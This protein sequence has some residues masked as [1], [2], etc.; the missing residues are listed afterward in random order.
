[1][2]TKGTLSDNKN[3]YLLLFWAIVT[4]LTARKLVRTVN[5]P[6]TFGRLFSD[7]RIT[8][9][10][11][12]HSGRER[13]LSVTPTRQIPSLIYVCQWQWH[14]YVRSCKAVSCKMSNT[15]TLGRLKI[16][17]ATFT[18]TCP[19]CF[20]KRTSFWWPP[21]G[22]ELTWPRSRKGEV[23][24]VAI[25]NPCMRCFQKR[26]RMRFQCMDL[27]ES[28]GYVCACAVSVFLCRSVCMWVWVCVCVYVCVCM[29]SCMHV[30][31]CLYAWVHACMCVCVCGCQRRG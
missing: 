5:V 7:G 4:G 12:E 25:A 22:A 13:S 8:D 28:E 2:W 9:L 17:T 20:A 10:G 14:L 11:L 21:P 30:C 6:E 16:P 3:V 24:G 15:L 29:S 19:S 26:S 27:M 1:M 18:A 23:R 31:M